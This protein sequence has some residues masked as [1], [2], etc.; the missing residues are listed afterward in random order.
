MV[1]FLDY[2]MDDDTASSQAAK[3]KASLNT[4]GGGSNNLFY[5]Y[6]NMTFGQTATIR[7]LPASAEIADNEV[8]PKFW[9]AKK[10][11]RLRFENP[12]QADSEVVLQIPAMQMYTNC[13]TENDLV[14]KQAKALY[15]Q[16]DKLKKAGKEEEAKQIQA[17]ASYHWHR[18]ETIAQC[19]VIRSP[20]V[21]ENPPESLIRLVEPN[22]QIMNV[23]NAT[24]NSDD[25]EVKLEYWP[26]HGRKGTNFVIKKSQSGDWPKYDAGSCFSRQTSA[27]TTEQLDALESHGLFNLK[28]FLPARPTDAEYEVLADI[29][30]LSI[31]GER[32][33]NPDWEAHFETVKVY[34]TN[35]TSK[36]GSELDADTLQSQVRET[37]SRLSG[38]G[39]AN[40][41]EIMSKLT[42]T[43]A[44]DDDAEP[45][46]DEDGVISDE[47]EAEPQVVAT[48]T[49]TVDQ[50]KAAVERIK[51]RTSGKPASAN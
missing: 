51:G 42:Q 35:Q 45:T 25:P 18:G 46:V 49:K 22:K 48:P 24:L 38:T 29:V 37:M 30:R 7:F 32:V 9:E 21:E 3:L 6:K 50:V 28:D 13:K 41:G 12:E 39:S 26:V 19:F 4:R 11:I 17:K 14:L 34:K 16:A 36:S 40:A 20:F 2:M 5:R 27:W 8:Q 15:D 44:Q 10:V 23:I 33:W 31:E 1:S 43:E 47:A